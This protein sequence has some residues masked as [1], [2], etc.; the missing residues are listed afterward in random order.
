MGINKNSI[1]I[2]IDSKTDEFTNLAKDI[3]NHPQTALEETYASKVIASTLEKAGF[4]IE[5]NLGLLRTGFVASW[6]KGKPIIGFLGEYDALPGLSQK[7]SAKKKPIVDGGPGHGCGHNLLGIGSLGAALAFKEV[8]E[9][10]RIEGTIRYYGCPAEETGVGKVFMAK[11]AV[12][13]DLDV[14]LTWHPMYANTV[15]E[16]SSLAVYSF[17]INFY[18]VSAHAA[19]SPEMGKSALDAVILTDVGVNYLREHIIQQARVHSVITNGGLA[20]NVVPSYAQIW[21]YI[22]APHRDQ[23]EEI[24]LRVLDIAKGA[25][26]MTGTTF[27]TDF[28]SGQSEYLP[29]ETVGSLMLANLREVGGPKFSEEDRRFAKEL[30][31]TLVSG[32]VESALKSYGKS[33]EEIGNPLSETVIDHVPGM[34]KGT[35]LPA[36]TDVGDVSQITPTAQLTACCIPLGV[37]LHS[38]QSTA[39][40][41]SSIGFKGMIVASKAMAGTAVD[42]VLRPEFIK[43]AKEEFKKATGGKK[44]KSPLPEGA[45]P[46]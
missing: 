44:Y 6:G 17:K 1:S 5:W 8:L 31:E 27:D 10:E 34:D 7:V 42:L 2:F 43:T 25:S 45:A 4:S 37:T 28:L 14:A 3:W 20:P 18:G 30:Q 15:M 16:S 13:D 29:N 19:A 23:V 36:S 33:L 41:G 22:R 46:H 32:T 38:W 35:V 24:Y 11:A 9:K 26:L 40:V 21:Y 39:S 12:F